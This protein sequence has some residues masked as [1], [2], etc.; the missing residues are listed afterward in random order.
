MVEIAFEGEEILFRKLFVRK[1]ADGT[2][3]TLEL[4]VQK[5][6]KEIYH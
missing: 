3:E 5:A 6:T 4:I 1:Y 2:M